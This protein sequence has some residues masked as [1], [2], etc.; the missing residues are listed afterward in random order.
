[1]R[2]ARGGILRSW[3]VVLIILLGIAVAAHAQPTDLMRQIA[4]SWFLADESLTFP[5]GRTIKS[6]GKEPYGY[7][8]FDSDSHF[9][10]MMIRSDLPKFETRGS[11]TLQ[12]ND[13]IAKG[14][15]AYYGSYAAGDDGTSVVVHIIGS[16]FTAF[17]D[18][19]SRRPLEFRGPDEFVMHVLVPNSGVKTELVWRRAGK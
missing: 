6:W 13:A 3:T 12:Q 17:N 11:G 8:G 4:G 2:F 15:I 16:T 10:M 7:L 18:T 1:M 14:M 19:V 9:S 5:D